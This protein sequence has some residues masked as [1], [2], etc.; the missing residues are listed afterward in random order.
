MMPSL[1]RPLPSVVASR[2]HAPQA[3]LKAPDKTPASTPQPP[4]SP[5]FQCGSW[6]ASRPNPT[7]AA[8]VASQMPM[9]LSSTTACRRRTR[10]T[11]S[12]R[13]R[14]FSMSPSGDPG[15]GS[16]DLTAERSRDQRVDELRQ[17]GRDAP[18]AVPGI[19]GRDV[20][21]VAGDLRVVQHVVDDKGN[22]CKNQ[23]FLQHG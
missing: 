20:H 6:E 16:I 2:L 11:R 13:A 22:R 17:G 4:I 18:E 21:R 1:R 15:G 23:Y 7:P 8:M 12:P 3:P 5:R 14:Y 19:L 10:T 9:A